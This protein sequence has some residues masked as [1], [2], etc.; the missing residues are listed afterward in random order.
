MSEEK[1][2]LDFTVTARNLDDIQ[3]LKARHSDCYKMPAIGSL[4]LPLINIKIDKTNKNKKVFWAKSYE[5]SLFKLR[6]KNRKIKEFSNKKVLVVT[7]HI[8]DFEKY[9][10]SRGFSIHNLSF[11]I[12]V[13][14]LENLQDST[15]FIIYFFQPINK[16]VIFWAQELE[17]IRNSSEFLNFKYNEI[18]I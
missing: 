7:N 11:I 6:D 14:L 9:L 12:P 2:L 3:E 15:N 1:M 4:C 5:D 18:D 13:Q 8:F 17:L 10:I 16:L